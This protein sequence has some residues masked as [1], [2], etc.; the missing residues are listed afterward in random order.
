[1][2]AGAKRRNPPRRA[3][4]VFEGD[5]FFVM[6]GLATTRELLHELEVRGAQAGRPAEL[7]DASA[8]LKATAQGL[9]DW[10]PRPV[11][12]HRVLAS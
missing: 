4:I 10:L 6:L 3:V 1:M 8:D 11:L 7:H 9:L 2:V 12:D 5:P